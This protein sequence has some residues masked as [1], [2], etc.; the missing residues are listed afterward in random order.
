MVW[1]FM[2]GWLLHHIAMGMAAS[3]SNT[4]AMTMSRIISVPPRRGSESPR[5]R[6]ADESLRT[7]EQKE[8]RNTRRWFRKEMSAR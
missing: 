7:A 1:T 4:N 3:P 2:C 6:P 8:N 5:S